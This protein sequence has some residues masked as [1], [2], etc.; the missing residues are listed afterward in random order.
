MT[1]TIQVAVADEHR[2]GALGLGDS[3]MVLGALVGSLL[4]PP[5]AT[6]G[7]PRV[8]FWLAAA[9]CTAAAG[10]LARFAAVDAGLA[11]AQPRRPVRASSRT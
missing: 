3:V 1:Q 6:A 5:L 9:V 10:L 7:G 4:A 8:T 2:A 11:T